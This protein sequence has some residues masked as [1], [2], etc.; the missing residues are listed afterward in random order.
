MSVL[1]DQLVGRGAGSDTA[2]AFWAIR[3]L[4]LDVRKGETVGVI[5]RNGAG[6]STLLQIIA[7]TMEPTEGSVDVAGR[8]SPLLE[9][10]AGFNSD[11]SG[12]E[13][14]RLNALI[15]GAGDGLDERIERIEAFA[16]LGEF[17]DRPVSTYSSGMYARLAFAVAVHVDPEILIVDEI[18][19]VGDSA[20]QKKCLAKFYEIRDRGCTILLVSH[21]A[22]QIRSAC[23]R[24]LL[25]DRGRQLAFGE[26][27]D[28][29]QQYEALLRR[30]SIVIGAQSEPAATPTRDN[31]ARRPFLVRIAS[32]QLLD[33][34]GQPL[35]DL[36]SGAGVSVEYRYEI[37][38][39]LPEDGLAFVVNLYRH[40]EL[41]VFGTTTRMQGLEPFRA[42]RSGTVRVTFPSLALTN[43][44]YKW[45]VAVNDG[46][47]LGILAEAVPVCEVRVTDSFRAV[48]VIELQHS[49]S[50]MET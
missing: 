9:L 40:D 25:L 19:S 3:D 45:R 2:G 28:V 49:W 10:G 35:S 43:G 8:V 32:V 37:D 46:V 38:G 6:K 1:R 34:D 23:Q 48:G 36:E 33:L 17:F 18:L 13:N 20:F 15:I 29:T 16:E 39:P 12:R 50:V 11:F 5:G 24:A 44:T 26:P 4:A 14:A 21:D 22:Y 7:G 30:P 27:S 42:A 31:A 41:Y 47:G